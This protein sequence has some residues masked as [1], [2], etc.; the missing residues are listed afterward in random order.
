MY[1]FT[2][3][4]NNVNDVIYKGLNGTNQTMKMEFEKWYYPYDNKD[5]YYTKF[6]IVNKRKHQ[7]RFKEQT[8]TDGIKSLLWAKQCLINFINDGINK[9]RDNIIVIGWDDKRRRDVYVRA[10]IPIGFTLSRMDNREVLLLKI[11]KL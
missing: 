3:Y 7:Y 1:N 11:D 9:T 4:K 2:S 10:L 6:Y 8:G 5:I